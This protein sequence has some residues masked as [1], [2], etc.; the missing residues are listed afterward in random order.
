[1]V[2]SVTHLKYPL[3]KWNFGTSIYI[4][5]DPKY[6]KVVMAMYEHFKGL[7]KIEGLVLIYIKWVS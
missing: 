6:A 3:C 5:G 2:G 4:I 1:V 7:P